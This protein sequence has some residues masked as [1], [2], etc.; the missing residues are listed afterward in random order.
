MTW[1]PEGFRQLRQSGPVITYIQDRRTAL[2]TGSEYSD[3]NFAINV[4][5]RLSRFASR[6]PG[7]DAPAEVAAEYERQVMR[8][9]AR[10]RPAFDRAVRK[11]EEFNQ[12]LLKSL[13]QAEARRRLRDDYHEFLDKHGYRRSLE[14][15][16][17]LP[18]G[19]GIQ[20]A[21]D[22]TGIEVLHEGHTPTRVWY[23]TYTPGQKKPRRQYLKK[24]R[25]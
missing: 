14:W 18:Q 13:S 11:V 22:A 16:E 2:T 17:C 1:H 3:R 19:V 23:D 25:W 24:V 5:V 7:V 12:A 20:A 10:L 6:R 21:V 15:F 8:V 9:A 4:V